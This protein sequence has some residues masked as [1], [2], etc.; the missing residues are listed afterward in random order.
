MN[1]LRWNCKLFIGIHRVSGICTWNNTFKSWSSNDCPPFVSFFLNQFNL[2]LCLL[3]TFNDHSLIFRC[4]D[5]CIIIAVTFLENGMVRLRFPHVKGSSHD[6]ITSLCSGATLRR[7][8]FKFSYNIDLNWLWILQ[9]RII[10]III[11][12]GL[13][14]FMR[15][16]L[17]LLFSWRCCLC[18]TYHCA[19]IF[20]C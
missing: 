12:W 5:W 6:H 10:I 16:L 14:I 3:A 17:C 19:H 8:S 20:R 9:S 1:Q 7:I 4:S 15:W 11:V 18:C 2:I 13:I